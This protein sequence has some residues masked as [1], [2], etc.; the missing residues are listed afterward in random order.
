MPVLIATGGPFLDS[1][2]NAAV[3]LY[4][5]FVPMFLGYVCFGYGLSR[6]ETSVATTIT[7]FEPVVAAF[8]AVVIVG[9]RLSVFG[10]FGVLLVIICL[11]CITIPARSQR[12]HLE[13]P[14]PST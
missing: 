12:N 14:E 3:G 8:L 4:M 13:I 2:N 11:I 7:L 5:A 6:V 10:W 1:W 9:E